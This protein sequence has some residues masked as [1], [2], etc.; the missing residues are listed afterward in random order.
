MN[1][2]GLKDR[3]FAEKLVTEGMEIEEKTT[4]LEH[5]IIGIVSLKL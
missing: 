4:A 5:E 2:S 1:V 3:A